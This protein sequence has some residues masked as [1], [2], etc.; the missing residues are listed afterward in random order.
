MNVN[1]FLQV[2][3]IAMEQDEIIS[4]TLA[5]TAGDPFLEVFVIKVIIIDS[6]GKCYLKCFLHLYLNV[7]I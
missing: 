6:D 7:S 1:V 2:D 5:K 3:S 4:L